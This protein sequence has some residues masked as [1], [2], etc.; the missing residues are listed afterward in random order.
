MDLPI[1]C[2]IQ[3][4]LR[5]RIQAGLITLVPKICLGIDE[6]IQGTCIGKTRKARDKN[7][8]LSSVNWQKHSLNVLT[9]SAST[10]LQWT[11]LS[12]LKYRG[13]ESQ[14]SENLRS[15][16]LLSFLLIY[17][18]TIGKYL[19]PLMKNALSYIKKSS[20]FF[21][22]GSRIYIIIFFQHHL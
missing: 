9:L 1:G 16:M 4:R 22:E 7:L 6:I 12:K 15:Y 18:G 19:P 17:R 13:L 21:S 8:N 11:D 20:V 10:I 2:W 3:D 5:P 14:K